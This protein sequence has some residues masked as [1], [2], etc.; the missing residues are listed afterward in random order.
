M[1]IGLGRPFRAAEA[2]TLNVELLSLSVMRA[3]NKCSLLADRLNCPTRK[4]S[5]E[6]VCTLQFKGLH[7]I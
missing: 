5:P 1:W 7:V 3:M 6:A 4:K 2:A